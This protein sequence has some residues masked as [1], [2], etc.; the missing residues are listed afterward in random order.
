MFTF[1]A[2]LVFSFT[3]L[4]SAPGII[5]TANV[6]A[7]CYGS[8]CQGLNPY[9]TGCTSG[10]Y[11][12]SEADM[13]DSSSNYVGRVYRFWSPTCQA[14]WAE[15]QNDLRAHYS[16]AQIRS[17]SPTNSYSTLSFYKYTSVSPMAYATD[18]TYTSAC[19]YVEDG[20]LMV[21]VCTP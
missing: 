8:A 15:V 21:S 20:S 1:M 13:F 6:A 19:G 7:T 16:T 18:V 2:T 9:T 3:L 17:T 10:A 4:N 11:L 14:A 12:A 5:P